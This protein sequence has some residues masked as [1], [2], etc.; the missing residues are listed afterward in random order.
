MNSFVASI[1]NNYN[2]LKRHPDPAITQ[3]KT[4]MQEINDEQ[5]QEDFRMQQEAI[6]KSYLSNQGI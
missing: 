3:Y 5:E 6:L 2:N 1:M 4:I